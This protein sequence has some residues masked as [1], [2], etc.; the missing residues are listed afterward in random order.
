MMYRST[1]STTSSSK[2]PSALAPRPTH[3]ETGMKDLLLSRT[4][5]PGTTYPSMSLNEDTTFALLRSYTCVPH[6]QRKS[7]TFSHCRRRRRCCCGDNPRATPRASISKRPLG[8]AAEVDC[9]LTQVRPPQLSGSHEQPQSIMPGDMSG[10]RIHARC[11]TCTPRH[12]RQGKT[13]F[14]RVKGVRPGVPRWNLVVWRHSQ[15]KRKAAFAVC[16]KVQV[17]VVF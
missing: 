3:E 13:R 4:Q 17:S 1:A 16:V 6:I 7:H 2:Q 12:V 15:G 10:Q 9:G 14:F 11:R 5:R 8:S